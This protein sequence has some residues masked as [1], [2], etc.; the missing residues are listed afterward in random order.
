MNNKVFITGIG[1][2]S[3]NGLGKDEYWENCRNGI[4]GIKEI[5]FFNTEGIKTR[6]GG[7]IPDLDNKKLHSTIDKSFY[8][9]NSILTSLAAQEAISDA[10]ISLGEKQI[11]DKCGVMLGVAIG[12]MTSLEKCYRDFLVHKTGVVFDEFLAAMPNMPGNLLAMEYGFKGINCTVNTACASSLTALGMAYNSI[13]NNQLE[14]CLAGGCEAPLSAVILS[15]FEK[16]RLLN[17]KSNMQPDKACKPF[18]RD[19]AGIVLSEGAAIFIL[20]SEEHIKKRE[21]KALIEVC[22][23]SSANAAGH[24]VTPDPDAEEAVIRAALKDA[25]MQPEE[26]DY[27]MAHGTG[28]YQNDKVE[29]EVIKRVYSN[30]AS[31]IPVS[32]VKSMIGHSLGASGALSVAITSLSM[33]N[34]YITPTIN[35]DIADNNCDL[36]Y[37]ANTGRK[38]KI[39]KAA[40]H[41]FGLGG[42]NSVLIL[43]A[44][45]L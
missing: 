16:L 38:K 34:N 13:K 43:K 44:L 31:S 1:V 11:L 26:L 36:D 9:R 20:E 37:V 35:L 45:H 3:P 40:V 15:H 2:A 23:S 8:D 18:S 4:S 7:F 41:S 30:H 10:H 25:Q 12:G 29:T 33:L 22:G 19:R 6:I 17:T 24:I 39:T 32:S 42:N 21:G 28:T 14:I 5:D 27:I